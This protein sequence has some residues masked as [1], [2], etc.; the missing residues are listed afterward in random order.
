MDVITGYEPSVTIAEGAPDDIGELC[1]EYWRSENGVF[2]YRVSELASARNISVR[3]VSELVA[4][5]S[6]ATVGA[7]VCVVCLS[8][9]F[10]RSRTEFLEAVSLRRRSDR[11][12]VCRGCR[13]VPS[14]DVEAQA[15]GSEAVPCFR[16]GGPSDLRI[17]FF[18]HPYDWGRDVALCRPCVD[19]CHRLCHPDGEGTGA[20]RVVSSTPCVK[21]RISV[22]TRT[23]YVN[24]YPGGKC[25]AMTVDPFSKLGSYRS[26]SEAE[27]AVVAALSA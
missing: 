14:V 11:D 1:Y 24:E 25:W 6:C 20:S 12:Y 17:P 4:Q 2:A 23:G 13:S 19:V 21:H 22:G 7:F 9:E 5:C 18:E 3:G 27:A 15:P 8:S 16:C 10:F 26:R